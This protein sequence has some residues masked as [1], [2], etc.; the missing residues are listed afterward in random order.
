VLDQRVMNSFKRAFTLIELL[1]VIAII[2]TLI[3][4]LLPAV[5]A[6]REASRRRSCGNNLKQLG[7]A[8]G[9]Y[10]AAHR[11]LP[12]G[13]KWG[14]WGPLI[15][16]KDHGSMLVVLLPFMEQ[17]AIYNSV[18][19]SRKTID[20]Q[21]IAGTQT[22]IG[23]QPIASYLCPSD[24]REAL[25]EGL[26]PH[27]Y[28]ASRGPTGLFEN[29]MCPCPNPWSDLELARVDDRE[30]FAGP[31]TRVGLTC[32]LKDV[33]DGVSNTI[34]VGEVRPACSE[35]ARAGWSITNNGNGYCTTLITINYDTCNDE[36]PDLCQRPFNWTTEVG[37]K[38]A[39]PGG[40]QFLFGDG[41]VHFLRD[42]IDHQGY[43]YLGAKADGQAEAVEF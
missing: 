29:V 36:A 19:F 40:A 1:L 8:I 6:A 4:L 42:D 22:L 12:P 31:F 30:E 16:R 26:S 21:V 39:H 13:A 41:S 15:K 24:E 27:N 2:G 18:D 37:F 23:S 35:H 28:A 7:L 9:N 10:E 5:Q 34:F 32:K 33:T 14:R 38:S 43:Q 25:Y 11:T 20:R 3:A 17:Q